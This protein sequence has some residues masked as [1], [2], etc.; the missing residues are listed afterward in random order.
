MTPCVDV[1]R[2]RR[3]GHGIIAKFEL[4]DCAREMDI[5]SLRFLMVGHITM[6]RKIQRFPMVGHSTIRSIQISNGW[7][8]LNN[9][10][11]SNGWS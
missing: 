6:L 9:H 3:W 8:M 2:D 4:N 1:T 7:S 11:T 5:T 10:Q